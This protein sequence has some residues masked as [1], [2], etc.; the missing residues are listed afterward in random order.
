M[1]VRT[2]AKTSLTTDAV[3]D[4]SN[5]TNSK[6]MAIKGGGSTQ[7]IKIKAVSCSGLEASTS[8]PQLLLLAFDSTVGTTLTALTTGESDTF[9]NPSASALSTGAST[10]VAVSGTAPQRGKLYISHCGFNALG[11]VFVKRW[12]F[13]EEPLIVGNAAN[14]G[15]VSLSGFT[16]T[17]AGAIGPE[18]QFE[19]L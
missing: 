12:P 14:G 8:A 15:E 7:Q 5:L 6:Y 13:G 2:F 18:I 3:A 9:Q 19:T 1:A 17:T 11:G 4:T 10:F 16:G